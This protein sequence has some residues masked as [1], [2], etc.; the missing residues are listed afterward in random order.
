MDTVIRSLQ[1]VTSVSSVEVRVFGLVPMSE[2]P[3]G[4]FDVCGEMGLDVDMD[5][6]HDDG[7]DD[8]ECEVGWKTA[9]RAKREIDLLVVVR[10]E[11]KASAWDRRRRDD[12]ARYM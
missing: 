4:A 3:S 7:G 1:Q 10:T 8:G 5:S 9:A 2:R 11:A 12:A 6:L